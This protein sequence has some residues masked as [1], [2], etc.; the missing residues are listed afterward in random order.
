MTLQLLKQ[1]L[2]GFLKRRIPTLGHQFGTIDNFDV[3]SDTDVFDGPVSIGIQEAERGNRKPP[4]IHEA[5][6][7]GQP[8]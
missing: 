5:G 8:E 1:H 7:A 4:A 3:G 2:D 6:V